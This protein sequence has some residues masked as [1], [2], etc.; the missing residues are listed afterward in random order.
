MWLF[1]RKIP[2]EVGIDT[3]VLELKIK[4][5]SVLPCN[6]ACL[7]WKHNEAERIAPGIMLKNG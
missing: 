3:T 4:T 7:P 1:K 5:E 2:W 6:K